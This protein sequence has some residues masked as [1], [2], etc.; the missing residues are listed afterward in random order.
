MLPNRS[1][2]RSIGQFPVTRKTFTMFDTL[3][4][5]ILGT[6]ALGLLAA[7]AFTGALRRRK[8]DGVERYRR[9][10]HAETHR[11]TAIRA[12]IFG[13]RRRKRL[14]FRPGEREAD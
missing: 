13:D 8:R 2:V 5:A 9:R 14:T 1:G 4:L 11:R 6:L 7:T 12:L 3:F 10:R